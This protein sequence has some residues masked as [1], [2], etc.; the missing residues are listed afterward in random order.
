MLV[1]AQLR[2]GHE[3][4]YA[5]VEHAAGANSDEEAQDCFVKGAQDRP[6]QDARKEEPEADRAGPREHAAAGGARPLRTTGSFS[7]ISAPMLRA[8]ARLSMAMENPTIRARPGW[9]A[10]PT[11]MLRPSISSSAVVPPASTVTSSPTGGLR[12]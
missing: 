11:P 3:F 4:R 2:L 6:R 8:S 10:A 1:V 5:Q 12:R 9:M 7:A